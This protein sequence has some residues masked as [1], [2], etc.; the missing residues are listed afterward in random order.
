MVHLSRGLVPLSATVVRR[1]IWSALLFALPACARQAR[2]VPVTSTV[3]DSAGVPIIA[4]SRPLADVALG[5]AGGPADTA[6]RIFQLDSLTHPV[7]LAFEA[8]GDVAIVDRGESHIVVVDS[9]GE[10]RGIL[11][12]EG[13]GPGEFQIAAGVAAIG[14]G[15]VLLQSSPANTLTLLRPGRPP[16][17]VAPP[18]VG[19]W[20]GWMWELPFIALEFPLQSAPEIWSRRLRALDDSSVLVYVGPLD[21]DTSS[22]ARGHLLRLRGDLTLHDT[23]ASFPPPH[24]S[25]R[26]SEDPRAGLEIVREVWGARPVWAAGEGLI[27][28]AQSDHPDVEIRNSSGRTVAIVRAPPARA[29]VTEEDRAALG[30]RIVQATL[31]VTPGAAERYRATSKGERDE[32]MRTFM[33]RFTLAP[34]RPEIVALFVA[35]RCLWMAGFDPTD[36][37]DGTAHEWLVQDLRTPAMAPRVMTIGAAGERVVAIQARHAATIW[38]DGEGQR[39]VGVYLLPSCRSTA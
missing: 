13:N 22:S 24:R 15:L 23:I 14:G 25:T 4:L 19:D 18:I 21:A 38:L 11:G 36:E 39:H 12:R 8:S 20:D 27:A 2:P 10:P 31:A 28:L 35:D 33:A 16:I 7:A 1:V 32:M 29:P 17:A 34:L 3:T 5:V 37:A 30:D 26:V 9:T 6:R